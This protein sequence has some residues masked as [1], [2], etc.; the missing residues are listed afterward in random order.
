MKLNWFDWHHSQLTVPVL[1][2]ILALRSQV[3][4]VEQAC[5]YLDIDGQDL[6]GENRHI[7]GYHQGQLVACARLL[8]QET[9]VSIGRVIVAPTARGQSLGCRVL[10]QALA[11]C[12][13]HWPGQTLTLSAQAHL[14]P[15]Y[16]RFGFVAVTEVY[17]EDGIEHIGMRRVG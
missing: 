7:A 1:Y 11:A 10:E 15:F 9:S 12:H 5:A 2:D 3:F 8:N 14:Q 17:L 13:T 6:I 16:R 4:V